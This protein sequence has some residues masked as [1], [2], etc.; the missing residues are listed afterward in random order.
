MDVE[1]TSKTTG[2]QAADNKVEGSGGAQ[3]GQP[4]D[5]EMVSS[6]EE[7][8]SGTSSH[9]LD[10]S[11]SPFESVEDYQRWLLSKLELTLEDSDDDENVPGHG[12]P[13]YIVPPTD[14]RHLTEESP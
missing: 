13:L 3:E 10:K 9:N 14:L 11:D 5:V 12:F 7:D 6:Q 4:I 2:E 8:N 1:D